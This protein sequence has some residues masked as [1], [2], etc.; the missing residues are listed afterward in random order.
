MNIGVI[1]IAYNSE[2]YIDDCLDSWISLK[3]KHN[4]TI[5]CVSGM[6]KDYINL[7]FEIKNKETLKKLIE[8][9]IDYLISTGPNLLIDENDSRNK[10]LNVLKKESDILWI[11]DSDEIYSESDIENI[12]SFIESNPDTD[13]FSVNFKNYIFTEKTFISG[14]CPP[15]IFRTKKENNLERF[16]FDNHVIYEDGSDFLNHPNL[17]IPRNVAWV[18]HFSWLN[19]D[20]RSPE[21]VKYQNIRFEN[22]CNFTWD[23]NEKKLYFN[24]EYYKKVEEEKPTLI[25]EIDVFTDKFTFNFSREKNI[26][27]INDVIEDNT[28]L[29]RVYNGHNGNLLSESNLILYKGINLF[30]GFE[31][32]NFYNIKNFSKFRIEALKDD[33]II[34]NQ[35]LYI[36]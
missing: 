16:Y 33:K 10:I 5:T 4:I 21:K 13:W 7:G 11:L 24:E 35:F 26:F 31:H 9:D 14:Y 30:Y 22:G 2:K 25:E 18:K 27:Y 12:L 6:F 3:K 36:K 20:P 23:E 28:I 29:L 8:K 15:R 1:L 19:T 17:P 34:H 32:E